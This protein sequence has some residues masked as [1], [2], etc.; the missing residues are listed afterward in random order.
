MG[1]D[2][3]AFVDYP[4]HLA[5][6]HIVSTFS[7]SEAFSRFY[8][9]RWQPVPYLAMDAAFLVLTRIASIYDAGRI[10]IGLCIILPVVAVATLHYAIHRRA[11]LV[12]AA[13]FLLS[14][15]FLLAWGFLNYLASVSLAVILF[16]GWIA[17]P[18]WPRRRR[19]AV[20]A[21][22]AGLLY[23]CHLMA[24]A[25]YLLLVGGF[26]LARAWR[27]GFGAWRATLTDWLVA[28]LQAVPGILLFLSVDEP[29]PLVGSVATIYGDL[30]TKLKSLLS[31]V[32]FFDWR[33]D[34]AT[35]ALALV[36]LVVGLG[37]GCLRLAPAIWPAALATGLVAVALPSFLLGVYG[38]DFRLPLLVAMVL[39]AALSVSAGVGRG[40]RHASLGVLLLL[41]GGRAAQATVALREMDVQIAQMRQVLSVM[42]LG[43]RLLTIDTAN[44][45]HRLRPGARTVSWHAPL[46]AVIDRDAF[47]PTLFGGILEVKPLP[48]MRRSTSPNGWRYPT[49][50]AV[51][52]GYGQRDDPTVDLGDGFGGRIYWIGWEEKFDYVMIEHYGRRP[53]TVP[54]MLQPVAT[55]EVVDLYRIGRD[56]RH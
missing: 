39:V 17:T 15:N 22:L 20:F 5:R 16:A 40:M 54:A 27:A 23:L 50:A 9:L 32:L 18:N 8:E 24:F 34:V 10:F 12:P 35:A 31:P 19:A 7:T 52:A 51:M 11:S 44:R 26:E 36:G 37:T 21:V 48:A 55:S 1:V 33:I 46:V 29:P 56:G 42:P 47:V 13:A 38:M 3:P 45:E 30:V 4:N 41:V 6:M 28:A 43:M 2:V 25:A 14:Y 53:T 49:L